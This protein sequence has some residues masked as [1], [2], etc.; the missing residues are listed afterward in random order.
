MELL[1]DLQDRLAG[2][3]VEVAGRF[4]GHQDRRAADERARDGGALLLAA[5]QL[6]RPV[7]QAV[8]EPDE[9]EALDR[10]RAALG[11]GD[12]L[13]EQ[14]DLDV[15]GD[16]QLGDE[17]EGLEDEADLL[18]AHAGEL[19]VAELLDRL[20]V[21][22][23][24]ARGRPVEAA[25]EVHERR[26]ARTRRTHDRDV[27]AARDH[28]VEPAEG[29]DEDRSVGLEVGLGEAGEPRGDRAVAGTGR[30]ARRDGGRRGVAEVERVRCVHGAPMVANRAIARRRSATL[31]AWN[32]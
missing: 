22:L 13:V 24:A 19:V 15:L 11:G 17:V 25:E 14:R 4:V 2:G 1:E 26:L 30:R 29:L 3:G 10:A 21:E 31:P 27:L 12:A 23:V 8:L 20:A 6:A 16:R 18:A 7:V 32:S 5:R 28:E 9:R